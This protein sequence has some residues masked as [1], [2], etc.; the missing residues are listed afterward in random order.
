MTKKDYIAFADALKRERPADH[1]DANKHV[2]WNLD[3]RAI[4][5]V[6]ARDNARFDR[7]RFLTA[8]GELS[9]RG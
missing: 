6:L 8:C 4:A 5:A 3:V 9:A 7:E 2:Q 1:W